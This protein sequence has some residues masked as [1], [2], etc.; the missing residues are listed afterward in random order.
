MESLVPVKVGKFAI[1]P[2]PYNLDPA[3]WQAA[4]DSEEPK[5]ASPLEDLSIYE[6]DPKTKEFFTFPLGHETLY[7]PFALK[8]DTNTGYL[9][10]STTPTNTQPILINNRSFFPLF[11]DE[12]PLIYQVLHEG[13]ATHI[14]TKTLVNFEQLCDILRLFKENKKI[15]ILEVSLTF[16]IEDFI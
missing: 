12:Q 2:K 5:L 15:Y 9:F 11:I 16:S 10:V 8:Q 14:P 6:L 1:L 3:W 7:E 4:L 13:S